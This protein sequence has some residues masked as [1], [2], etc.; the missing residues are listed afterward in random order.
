MCESDR[1]RGNDGASRSVDE[2]NSNVGCEIKFKVY[3]CY[4]LPAKKMLCCL[5]I[6]S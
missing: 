6:D 3:I 4:V 5:V 2:V 1:E